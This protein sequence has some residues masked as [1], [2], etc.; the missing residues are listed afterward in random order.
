M[1]TKTIYPV[2]TPEQVAQGKRLYNCLGMEVATYRNWFSEGVPSE[3]VRALDAIQA[4]L[5]TVKRAAKHA[6]QAEPP[7]QRQGTLFPEGE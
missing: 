1:T 3:W 2:P 5:M 6:E 4:V 7:A